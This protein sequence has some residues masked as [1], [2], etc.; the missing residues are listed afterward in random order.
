MH[1][2]ASWTT[3]IDNWKKTKC[4][5][6][7]STINTIILSCLLLYSISHLTGAAGVFVYVANCNSYSSVSEM[8]FFS[9]SHPL[10]WFNWSQT[11]W[12]YWPTY[13]EITYIYEIMC[14]LRLFFLGG[15]R[16]F[17]TLL[18]LANMNPTK[19][20]SNRC[21]QLQ[22]FILMNILLSWQVKIT[23]L[24]ENANNCF[25]YSMCQ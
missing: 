20:V 2:I 9:F 12:K 23:K 3:D 16:S 7:W 17:T 21:N 25:V 5:T 24:G 18:N 4:C 8:P 19:L 11:N 14:W 6:V 1:Y 10:Y 13:S 15:S 22:Y